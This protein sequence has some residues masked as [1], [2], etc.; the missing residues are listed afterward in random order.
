MGFINEYI[1]EEAAKRT[2]VYEMAKKFAGP[3]DDSWTID[4][5]RNIFLYIV[6]RGREEY[7]SHSTWL[8]HWDSEYIVVHLE[9][10]EHKGKRGEPGWS[11]WKLNRL[12]APQKL[13]NYQD[14]IISDL[15]EAL[16]AYKDFGLSSV[17]TDYNITLDF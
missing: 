15:K 6:N 5:K 4:P 3:I 17:N 12:E 1:S 14:D 13:N 7:R 8:F 16:I 10:L 9:L 2:G 11:H